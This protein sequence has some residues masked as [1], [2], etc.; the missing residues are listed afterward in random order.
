MKTL[1]LKVPVNMPVKKIEP[2]LMAMVLVMVWFTLQKVMLYNDSTA[3][4]IDQSIWLLVLLAIISFLLML[5]LCYWLMQR[6][7][8]R[9]GLPDLGDMVLQFSSL[10]LWQQLKFALALFALLLSAAIGV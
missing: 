8:L 3:G 5:G 1:S 2:Y 6:F 4:Q 10:V 9:M 7:W